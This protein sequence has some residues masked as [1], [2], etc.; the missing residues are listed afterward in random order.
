M[1]SYKYFRKI[2]TNGNLL[3]FC[4]QHRILPRSSGEKNGDIRERD[5]QN[6]LSKVNFPANSAI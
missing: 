4:Q 1:G 3:I 5:G 6:L 2:E